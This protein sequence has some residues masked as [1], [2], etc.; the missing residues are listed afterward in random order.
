M[1][2]ISVEELKKRKES[3]EELFILDVREPDEYK[4][5]NMGALLI[6]LGQVMNGQIDAIEDWKDKE[7][8][9]HCRSGKRSLTA[10]LVLEQMGFTNTKNLSGG[11]LAWMEL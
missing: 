5:S 1:Q 6:P 9:V 3:G 10:C 2:N 4:E 11:I 7:V 8:I